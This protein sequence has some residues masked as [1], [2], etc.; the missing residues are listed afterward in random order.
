MLAKILMRIFALF[1]RRKSWTRYFAVLLLLQDCLI[2]SSF[3]S[4][5]R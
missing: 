3:F 4:L 5:F 2:Y 1:L